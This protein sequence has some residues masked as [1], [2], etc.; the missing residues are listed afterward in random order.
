MKKIIFILTVL[1]A[2]S[3]NQTVSKSL[4]WNTL[5]IQEK[6]TFLVGYLAGQLEICKAIKDAEMCS[7]KKLENEIA[8]IEEL[9]EIVNQHSV[10]ESKK[11]FFEW[12]TIFYQNS[13]NAQKP[14]EDAIRWAQKRVIANEILNKAKER[15]R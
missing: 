11:V 3:Q 15:V 8:A 10:G 13:S 6:S 2:F 5:R 1:L 14:I 7:Q 12:I 4:M 9:F